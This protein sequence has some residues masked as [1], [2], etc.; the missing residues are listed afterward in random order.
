GGTGKTQV[1]LRFVS[2]NSYR[3][4]HVWFFDAT[5]D[6]TLAA[7]FKKLGKAAGIGESVNDVRDFLGRMHED[8]LM[9][10]DNADG[11]KIDL[12]KYIP[13]CMHGNVIITSRITEVHQMASPGFH[14]D[15]SD[16]EQSEAID[17][18]LKHSHKNSNNYN[19]QLAS[20]IVDV[21]GCQA[22]VVATAG[23]YIASTATCTLSNYL[24]L[25]KQKC[26]QLFNYKM[27]SLDGYQNT[28]FSAFQ[29][30][31]NKLSLSAKLFMQICAFFHHTAIPI[32][33]FYHASAFTGNDLLPEEK[34][35]NLVVEKLIL[36]LSLFT[37]DESWDEAID[38]LSHLSLAM[39]DID[40]KT[41]SFHSILQMCVQETLINK[42][43][44]CCVAQLLLACAKPYGITNIDY[45]FQRMLIPHMDSI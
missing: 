22:L 7:D 3:F 18:L 24:S 30:S 28:V 31:F 36:F 45:Q 13:Q 5:S 33:L 15:F 41:V 21:L 35:K 8:W 27:K 10:F 43:I 6:S 40:A 4:L 1:V 37:H 16:L 19:Q 29:L 39:Y 17:L 9:I 38:E 23:A 32:E 25:F 14:F 2:E 11:P 26:R 42:E 34:E 12:G 20:D 44:P